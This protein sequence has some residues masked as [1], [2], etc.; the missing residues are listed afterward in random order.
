MIRFD[1]GPVL[2]NSPFLSFLVLDTGSLKAFPEK[3]SPRNSGRF[4]FNSYTKSLTFNITELV[5]VF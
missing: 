1:E 5:G 3:I 4:R 2:R